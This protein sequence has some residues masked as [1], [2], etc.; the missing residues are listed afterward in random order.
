M[1]MSVVGALARYFHLKLPTNNCLVFGMEAEK[2]Q[3]G[4]TSGLDLYLALHGGCVYRKEQRNFRHTM[5]QIPLRLI[6]TGAAVSSTG[7]CVDCAL[8]YLRRLGV[9]DQF[10]KVTQALSQALKDNDVA[11]IHE[12]VRTNH[13]LLCQLGV[14]PQ[15]AQRFIDAIE[16][17]HMSA[18]ISGA[19]SVRGDSCGVILVIGDDP[20]DDLI[21]TYNYTLLPISGETRGTRI[22][23][24]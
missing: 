23:S 18:K 4:L 2:L 9:V 6:N 19:G 14:V 11:T 8:P 7:E 12:C 22:I 24:R 21:Q 5:P 17:R 16:A 13:R 10:A 3:H 20:I 15:K 1:I